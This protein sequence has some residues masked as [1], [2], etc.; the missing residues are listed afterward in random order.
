MLNP[1]ST[2]VIVM[3]LFGAGSSVPF[4][5]PGMEGFTKQFLDRYKDK[6]SFI[7]N[8][9]EAIEE[10]EGII[11]FPLSFDLETLLAVLNDLSGEKKKPI[12]VPTTSLL[13]KE[14]LK[15]HEA[16]EKYG[17]DGSSAL[18]DLEE[19]IFNSCMQ[20]IKNGKK[21]GNFKL[22]DL[23]YGPLLT[24]LN[25]VGLEN[26]QAHIR[27]IYSTNWDICFKTWLDYRN[28][29]IDDGTGIDKQSYP[30]LDLSKFDPT[31]L[32]QSPSGIRYVPLHGSLD[33]VQVSRPKG[34]GAYKDIQKVPDPI[35]YFENKPSNLKNV[36]TIYPLEAIG[37]E[38]SVKSPYLDLLNHFKAV[39]RRE[40]RVF[41]IGYSLRDPTIGSIFEEVIAERMRNGHINLMSKD[42]DSRKSEA[43][44]GKH[45][46]RIIVVNPSPDKLV[47][48]LQKQS[49]LN[50]L[51]T[52]IPIKIRFPRATDPDFRAG[53]ANALGRL[54]KDLQ[55]IGYLTSGSGGIVLDELQSKYG[56]TRDQIAADYA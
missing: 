14:K 39:L 18:I 56:I 13:L 51:Q 28:I 45:S 22:F 41:I 42:L 7:I 32:D 44:S 8:I 54:F 17:K 12:S 35:G 55:K 33:L 27:N 23:F 20:P 29:P 46:F 10:S 4:D 34:L 1:D 19:F 53:Y 25:G 3:I 9:G 49:Q 37:Y 38:E 2:L 31:G 5:I 40:D 43:V 52:F 26:I 6:Y 30:I 48:N 36:F 15:L 21:E 50:L 24:L 11:G 16:R 47:D